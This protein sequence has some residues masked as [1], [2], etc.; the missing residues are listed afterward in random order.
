MTIEVQGGGKELVEETWGGRTAKIGS[1]RLGIQ[2]P[3]PRCQAT[4]RNPESGEVD[5]NTLK[6]IKQAR[7][8]DV[9]ARKVVLGMYCEVLKAGTVSVGD[10]VVF[11]DANS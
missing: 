10:E 2:S 3:V 11:E 6:A 9:E 5:F 8:M 4:T 7:K 1:V